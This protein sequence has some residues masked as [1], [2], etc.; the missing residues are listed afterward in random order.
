MRVKPSAEKT[1][2]KLNTKQSRRKEGTK[3][4]RKGKKKKRKKE[5]KQVDKIVLIKRNPR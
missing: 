4:R 5:R 1:F 2:I 3:G